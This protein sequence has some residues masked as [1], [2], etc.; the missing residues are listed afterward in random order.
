LSQD[1][2]PLTLEQLECL[3]RC[4]RGLSI[5][6][7]STSIIKALVDGGYAQRGVAGVITVTGKGLEHLRKLNYQ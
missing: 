1:E 7:E 5:R 3:S 4:A 6:F 2:P